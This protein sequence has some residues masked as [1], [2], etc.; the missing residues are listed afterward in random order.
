MGSF[1]DQFGFMQVES[2]VRYDF[3]NLVFI[4]Q[5]FRTVSALWGNQDAAISQDFHPHND[6]SAHDVNFHFQH[7]MSQDYWD[8]PE[9]DLDHLKHRQYDIEIPQF[10]NL[11]TLGPG[12]LSI[13]GHQNCLSSYNPNPGSS[14]SVKCLPQMRPNSCLESTW[15][16]VRQLFQGSSCSSGTGKC[17]TPEIDWSICPKTCMACLS[18]KCQSQNWQ[19]DTICLTSGRPEQCYFDGHLASDDTHVSISA[20]NFGQQCQLFS[21]D[22]MLVTLS[23]PKYG[24]AS[25]VVANGKTRPNDVLIG[26]NSLTQKGNN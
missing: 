22:P 4:K 21:N 10:T 5:H 8:R 6:P 19:P 1:T 11:G 9:L 20:V 2:P 24:P 18:V 16:K 13:P 25:F 3:H 14:Y 23:G 17:S 7:H 12:Y 26:N 15:I